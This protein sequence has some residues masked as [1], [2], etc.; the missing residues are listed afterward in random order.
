MTSNEKEHLNIYPLYVSST[1]PR[2]WRS[3]LSI[4]GLHINVQHTMSKEAK[5]NLVPDQPHRGDLGWRLIVT[6]VLTSV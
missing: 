5:P 2:V 4:D 3:N 6:L 1:S